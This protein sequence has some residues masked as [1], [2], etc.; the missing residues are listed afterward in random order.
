MGRAFSRSYIERRLKALDEEMEPLVGRFLTDAEQFRVLSIC[1]EQ[2]WLE[3]KL[4]EL[5]LR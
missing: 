3:S 2:N 5:E 4:A 1:D